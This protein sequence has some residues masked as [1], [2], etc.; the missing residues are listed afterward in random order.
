M[1][2]TD[3]MQ[4][5]AEKVSNEMSL[6]M[7]GGWDSFTGLGGDYNNTPISDVLPVIMKPKDDRINFSSPCLVVK[8]KDHE[9]LNSLPF[10][11][12]TPA[13]GGLNS[14]DVKDDSDILLSAAL[15]KASF[16]D[17]N[18][19]F[20]RCGEY[21]L[22]VVRDSGSF[23]TAAFAS[24]VAPHWVGPFVDW[25]DSRVKAQADQAGQIEVGNWY[26]QFFSNLIKWLCV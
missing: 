20:N 17:G 15:H 18:V 11:S 12:D 1:E 23:R 22:L 9:I 10:D 21:P 24:D 26:A 5:I 19:V 13:I 2:T 8:Q 14:F 4:K 7:I 25:G 3:Q 6:L 16:Q